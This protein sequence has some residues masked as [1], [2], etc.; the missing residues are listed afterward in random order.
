MKKILES[1]T[2]KSLLLPLLGPSSHVLL[3]MCGA[4]CILGQL[5]EGETTVTVKA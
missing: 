3:W 4:H 2:I 5:Q 1:V